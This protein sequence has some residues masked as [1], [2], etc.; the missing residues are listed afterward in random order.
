[1]QTGIFKHIPHLA[2]YLSF[3]LKSQISK[4]SALTSLQ[5]LFSPAKMAA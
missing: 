4:A 5:Q 3:N 1:M 2:T